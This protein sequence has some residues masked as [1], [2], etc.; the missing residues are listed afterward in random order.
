MAYFDVNA[1]TPLSPAAREAWLEA[2]QAHWHNPSSPYACAARARNALEAARRELAELLQINPQR[3]VFT[4]GATEANNAVLQNLHQRNPSAKVAISAIEHPCIFE[5]AEKLFSETCLKLPVTRQGVVDLVQAQSIITEGRPALVSVMAANNETGVIQPWSELRD[6]C[7]G[8][9][10]AFHC[11]A[12]QW[13]G[14]MPLEGLGA[15][16]Y[17]TGSAHKFGGPKGTGF[18]VI[19]EDDNGFSGQ[20]GGGQENDHRGGTENLPAVLAMMAALKAQAVTRDDMQT[21]AAFRDQLIAI[22]QKTIPDIHVVGGSAVRLPN[23]VLLKMPA[24]AHQRW[25]ARLDKLG[26]QVSTGSACATAKEGPSHVLRAMG[27]T[28]EEARRCIRISSASTTSEEDW[29]G[30][31]Q[32][33]QRVWQGLEAEHLHSAVIEL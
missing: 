16:D 9:G 14:K 26:F 17:L 32:A 27:Y 7:R 19:P 3:V 4:S 33:L 11:D 25:V 2:Q 30:L 10:I 8:L 22:V 24:H 23:T 5:P 1:T 15:C 18:L 20:L 12:A 31:A 21:Q 13:L 29:H 6:F 28:D